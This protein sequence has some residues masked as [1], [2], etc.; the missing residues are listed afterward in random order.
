MREQEKLIPRFR[1]QRAAQTRLSL[2]PFRQNT[3]ELSFTGTR[4]TKQTFP[5]IFT[6][7][8]HDPSLPTHDGKRSRQ[9]CAVHRQ[10][11]PEPL[12]RHFSRPRK[13]LQD[14]ELRSAKSKRT[15]RIF[16]EL[17]EGPRRPA[18]VSA[19]AGQVWKKWFA[20]TQMDA[21]TSIWLRDFLKRWGSLLPGRH[22]GGRR[23][24]GNP[25]RCER[26]PRG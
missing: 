24:G 13:H 17:G 21:Y 12:L 19:H 5:P 7:A 14:G 22:R 20:H 9:A 6:R 11:F 3:P 26:S 15:K 1:A 8:H 4:Q 16:V 10:H 25:R 2:L 18:D 23:R